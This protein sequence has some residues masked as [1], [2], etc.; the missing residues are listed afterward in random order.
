MTAAYATFA[1][2]GIR[3][4]ER[5]FTK[6]YDSEKDGKLNIKIGSDSECPLGLQIALTHLYHNCK[7]RVI[8]PSSLAY[9]LTGDN[10]RIPPSATLIYE[11]YIE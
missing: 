9:G 7:A 4:E 5:T 1:N 11:I 3:R 2:N 10:D 8:I 6:V